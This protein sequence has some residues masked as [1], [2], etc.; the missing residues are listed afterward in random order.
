MASIFKI[1]TGNWAY[2]VD[3]GTNSVTGKRKQK[4]KS[5]FSTQKKAMLAASQV[6]LAL[7][8]NE[9]IPDKAITFGKF[10]QEWFSLYAV[11]AKE[12]SSILRKKQIRILN[13]YL[14]EI[15]L[16]DIEPRRYQKLILALS[17]DYSYNTLLGIHAVSCMIFK[18]AVQ[19]KIISES[20]SQYVQI[21]KKQIAV[22][23]MAEKKYLE[24]EDLLHFLRVIKREGHYQDYELFLVLAYTGMRIG[25]VCALQWTDIDIQNKLISI[26]KTIYNDSRIKNFTYGTPKTKKSIRTIAIDDVVVHALKAYQSKQKQYRLAHAN[27]FVDHNAVFTSRKFPGYPLNRM[28]AEWK[29]K[30]YLKKAHLPLTLTPHSLRHTHVSLLAEA[31]VDLYEIM[32]RLGH[33]NDMTTRSIYL[34]ITKGKQ[35]NASDRFARLLQNVSDGELD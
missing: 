22:H 13:R 21:P 25:E 18:K 11:N 31:G 30:Y 16:Q 15:R 33:R 19:F 1:C 27:T 8:N 14:G 2:R 6:Q 23:M 10:A 9:Y 34:H 5:G 26:T 24:K 28:A 7:S 4:Y 3:I 17:K 29:M 20:P 32:E 35:R 12:Q